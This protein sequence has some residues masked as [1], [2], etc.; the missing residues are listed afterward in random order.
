MTLMLAHDFKPYLRRDTV[1]RFHLSKLSV[2]IFEMVNQSQFNR[3]ARAL[4]RLVEYLHR[5]TFTF[6][7]I[8]HQVP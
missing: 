5:Y 8:P 7:R 2:L 6:H 3:Q 1:C 4:R